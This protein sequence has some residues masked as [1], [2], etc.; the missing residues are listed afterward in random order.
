MCTHQPF[1]IYQGILPVY[2]TSF[3]GKPA[4][5]IKAP[6]AGYIIVSIEAD[7]LRRP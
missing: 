1:K 6:G 7:R 5:M 3:F 2:Y 4:L